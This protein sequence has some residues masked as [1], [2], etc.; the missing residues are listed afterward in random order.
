M[1]AVPTSSA[2]TVSRIPA[3]KL[4]LDKS[5]HWMAAETT[6]QGCTAVFS[7][8][9]WPLQH[10]PLVAAGLAHLQQQLHGA[11]WLPRQGFLIFCILGFTR[12][13]LLTPK[14]LTPNI[15][16]ARH[17]HEPIMRHAPGRAPGPAAPARA[18][19]CCL[20][21]RDAAPGLL[22]F[23]SDLTG[24]FW[25]F[26]LPGQGVSQQGPQSP[27]A[28]GNPCK[29]CVSHHGLLPHTIYRTQTRCGVAAREGHLLAGARPLGANRLTAVPVKTAPPAL[30][31][32]GGASSV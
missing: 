17:R 29:G 22:T 3:A 8:C 7:S 21:T 18:R 27:H 28:L 24:P 2:T 15:A 31:Y 10:T 32:A 19:C 1:S 11:F 23:S 6:R 13:W 4:A 20:G 9:H 25:G 5:V 14:A 26:R 12:S 16:R 30:T